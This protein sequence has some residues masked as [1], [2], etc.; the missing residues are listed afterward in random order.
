MRA[1]EVLAGQLIACHLHVL[2]LFDRPKTSF[3]TLLDRL[4]PFL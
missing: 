1:S 3:A 2:G 4:E